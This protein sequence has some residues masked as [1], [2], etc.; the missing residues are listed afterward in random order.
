ML[1]VLGVGVERGITAG[2]LLSIVLYLW[3][4]SRPHVAV[5]GE[6][7]GT[8]HFRNI[9]RHKVITSE[10]VLSV[11]VDES[12][13]F[14]NARYLDDRIY[15]LVAERRALQHVVLMCSA[16]NF[17]DASALESLEMIAARLNA[18]GVTFHLSEVKGSVMDALKR[19]EFFEHFAGEVF[20][21]QYAAMEKLDP[22]TIRLADERRLRRPDGIRRSEGPREPD[23]RGALAAAGGMSRPDLALAR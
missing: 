13:Y 4:T 18:A 14:V 9:L 16:I 5:V 3:R 22:A 7:P 12:L 19:S 21:S 20:L 1:V 10:T 11:R 17:I 23:L 2:V 8:E 15:S 6:V